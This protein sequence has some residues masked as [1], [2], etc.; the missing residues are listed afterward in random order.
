ML[1]VLQRCS[2]AR[3]FSHSK[4]VVID[5]ATRG[6]R[7]LTVSCLQQQSLQLSL[8]HRKKCET[9]TNN[10]V[11]FFSSTLPKRDLNVLGFSLLSSQ[12]TAAAQWLKTES[13]LALSPEEGHPII[14]R[15]Q[16]MKKVDKAFEKQKSQVAVVYLAGEP[17]VGKSQLGRKYGENYYNSYRQNP[18]G[19]T[20]LMLDMS[21]FQANY[22]KL[23]IKL[24]VKSEVANDWNK[25]KK[26]AHVVKK[27]LSKR[28]NWLLILDNYNSL[29]Y[30]GLDRGTVHIISQSS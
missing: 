8:Y 21:D 16:E 4:S 2:I 13:I 30:E 17:G 10:A 27:V 25:P 12:L 29:T 18:V 7:S 23:A 24:G 1:R 28:T 9:P 15:P 19:G 3:V 6:Q 14:D 20:V 11:R 5:Q 22:S 26:I